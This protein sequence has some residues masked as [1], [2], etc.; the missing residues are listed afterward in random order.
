MFDIAGVIA[1][2]EN[3]MG[4]GVVT[5]GVDGGMGLFPNIDSY[6]RASTGRGGAGARTTFNP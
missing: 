1:V 4:P 5:S 6:A 3:E 2:D